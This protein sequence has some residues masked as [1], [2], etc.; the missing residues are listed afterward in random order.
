MKV[1]KRFIQT[2]AKSITVNL[3]TEEISEK[4]IVVRMKSEHRS[5]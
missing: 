5:V 2:F 4:G 1:R 3:M